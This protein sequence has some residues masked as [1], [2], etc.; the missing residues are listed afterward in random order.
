MEL[1]G[2]TSWREGRKKEGRKE[3]RK[4]EKEEEGIKERPNSRQSPPH[5]ESS[6]S[7]Q[8]RTLLHY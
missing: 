5:W 8:R 6:T 2:E 3:G 4:E 1:D 7:L